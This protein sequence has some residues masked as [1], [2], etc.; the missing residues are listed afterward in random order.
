MT[1]WHDEMSISASTHVE[2]YRL[3]QDKHRIS[4]NVTCTK[5]KVSFPSACACAYAYSS[6][7]PVLGEATL[8]LLYS[9]ALNRHINVIC[10]IFKVREW[11][12]MLK[13]KQCQI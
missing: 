11:G 13:L 3:V 6:C 10:S 1:C 4:I 2:R 5:G 12:N 9:H 7:E 8:N